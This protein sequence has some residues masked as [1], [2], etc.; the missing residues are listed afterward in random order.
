MGRGMSGT[1]GGGGRGFSGGGG[2]FRPSTSR[3]SGVHHHTSVHVHSGGFWNG[4]MFGSLMASRNGTSGGTGGANVKYKKTRNKVATLIL[5][6]VFLAIAATCIVCANVFTYKTIDAT[7]VSYREADVYSMYGEEYYYC[8]YSYTV[9]GK[10][11]TK[12]S[13]VYFEYGGDNPA[14]LEEFAVGTTQRIKYKNTEPTI[15][16]EIEGKKHIDDDFGTVGWVFGIIFG[17]ITVI[18]FVCGVQKVE[19]I[20]EPAAEAASTSSSTKLEE[21]KVRCK[22]CGS[23]LDKDDTFCTGCGARK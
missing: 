16:Y 17:V 15:I 7:V 22:Y 11:Y 18:V 4:L 21:G 20:E 10:E 2:G 12:E 14:D 8:T 1:G 23:I 6:I 19:V 9:K 13:Q 3:P 5:G